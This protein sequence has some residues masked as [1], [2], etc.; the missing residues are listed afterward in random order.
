M[1]TATTATVWSN[2]SDA[3]FRAWGSWLS[4]QLAA[5][6]WTLVGSVFATGTDWT[7]V[8]AP[9]SANTARVTELWRMN[10]ALQASAPL[11]MLLDYGEGSV[12]DTP[13]YRIRLGTG[14]SAPTTL[15]GQFY[16]TT[17]TFIAASATNANSMT[18]Y[19]SG[20]S[21][22]FSVAFCV[23]GTSWANSNPLGFAIERRKDADGV[24][25]GTGWL[26]TFWGG[27][28]TR[29]SGG[30]KQDGSNAIMGVN[31]I[32]GFP[33]I[34]ATEAAL[35]FDAKIAVTPQIFALLGPMEIGINLVCLPQGHLGPGATFTA[36]VY[37]A[38]HTFITLNDIS[39]G[40]VLSG[41]VANVEWAMRYE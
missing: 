22:R 39:A 36:D 9:A 37:G 27:T 30:F 5:M 6:G 38:T 23:S 34:T 3:N 12:A 32:I 16:D 18:H 21:S 31:T 41:S 1:S 33:V 11:Y 14:G 29:R 7:D 25:V 40:A 13:G 35:T 26:V 28:T 4:A 15:T 19:I 8:T 2:S 10:D 17:A 24:E 20:T